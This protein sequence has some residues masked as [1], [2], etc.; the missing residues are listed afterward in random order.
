MGRDLFVAIGGVCLMALVIGGLS[1][2]SSTPGAKP[3]E[4]NTLKVSV[5]WSASA[6]EITNKGSKEAAGHQMTVYINGTPPFAFEAEAPVPTLGESVRI[7]LMSFVK[8]GERFN[9]V[10]QAV[11]VAWVGGHGYDYCSFGK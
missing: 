3:S 4:L 6:V 2:P 1:S 5:A 7:P 11:Y 8:T 10:T 9:P